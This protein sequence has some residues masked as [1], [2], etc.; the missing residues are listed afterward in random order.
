MLNILSELSVSFSGYMKAIVKSGID[1]V[2][3]KVVDLFEDI[4]G[5]CGF[6]KGSGGVTMLFTGTYKT[7]SW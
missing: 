7:F 3:L 4:V 1:I 6:E 5:V 2:V